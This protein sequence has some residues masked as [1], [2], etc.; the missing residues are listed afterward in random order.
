MRRLTRRQFL[1]RSG[2]LVAATWGYTLWGQRSGAWARPLGISTAPDHTTLALTYAPA[3]DGP[4]RLLIEA[5]GWPM[6]VR[7]L[8]GADP[9]PGREDRREVLAVIVHLTDVHVIDTQAPTRVEFLD[10]DADPPQQSVPFSS[11]W[12]AQEL[13]TT[14]VADAMVRQL[15][16][17]GRGPVTGRRFDVAVPT[18]DNIDNQ[19]YN[20]LVW[21]LRLLDG[22]GELRPNSGDPDTYEG[23]QDT[24][25]LFYDPHYW[26][27]DPIDDPRAPDH[28][29][30]YWGFPDYPGLIEA[31]ITPF[32]P[33]GLDVPWYSTYG[34]HDGLLSGNMPM[35]AALDAF[36]Q[37]GLKVISRPAGMT[38]GDLFN[39]LAAGDPTAVAALLS[40]PA[41]PVTPDPDRRFITPR[42]WV[43]MHL[44]SPPQPGPPGHGYTAANL[45]DGTLYY[46]FPIAPG[47]VG[48]SL[49]TVNRGGYADGSIG[50]RQLAWLEEQLIALHSRYYAPDGSEV[51]T[52]HGDA[53]VVLFSHHNIP[54]M[55]NPIPDPALPDDRRILGDEFEAFLHRF[56]NVVCWI[57]GHSHMNRVWARPDPS[58]RT[59]GFWEINTAAHVDYP[60]HSRIVEIVD[61]HDGTLSIFA[62]LVDHAGPARA[63]VAPDVAAL[64]AISR[65]LALND[66]QLDVAD[67]LGAPED[68]N[69]ELLVRRPFDRSAAPVPPPTVGV[70]TPAPAP[71]PLPTTGG[72]VVLAGAAVAAAAVLRRRGRQP[73]NSGPPTSPG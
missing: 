62:T 1:R 57:N 72:G 31:A 5:P 27:P 15:R 48:I 35:N 44:D 8:P 39:G 65:E 41:R 17:I 56:P 42:D 6:L 68:R 29:K 37:G 49:D 26:H 24:D 50:A 19:Q 30:R 9:R 51:R 55:V 23:V 53:L 54:T 33:V 64:A 16:R 70:G 36:N 66:P 61:N 10:R 60:E 18:G 3:G 21:F 4:Y 59:G 73:F 34:N 47:V 52:D 67:K 13:L 63:E 58:G 38:S 2:A 71:P 43:Q 7:A 28:Y 46:T 25:P 22:G 45:E 20:E 11:A 14:Q 12:R 32:T 69:V 40:A